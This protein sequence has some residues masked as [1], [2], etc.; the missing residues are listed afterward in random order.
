MYIFALIFQV[1]LSGRQ[2]IT[3]LDW[4]YEKVLGSCAGE[5]VVRYTQIPTAKCT[6]VLTITM[7]LSRL[8]DFDRSENYTL[9]IGTGSETVTCFGYNSSTSE[10]RMYNI[11]CQ[12]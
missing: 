1:K 7:A 10:L 8:W 11:L 9:G 3:C 6:L 12:T 2:K 5:E 4:T